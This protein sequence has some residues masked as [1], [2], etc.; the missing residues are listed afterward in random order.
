MR[1]AK[2]SSRLDGAVKVEKP[3]P[4]SVLD[5][6]LESV[7]LVALL[8]LLRGSFV[9]D[10]GARPSTSS[11]YSCRIARCRWVRDLGEFNGEPQIE[12]QCTSRLTLGAAR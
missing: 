9:D 6:A 8:E 10:R 3:V 11:A 2:P 12:R 7:L 1:D 4:F 5:V